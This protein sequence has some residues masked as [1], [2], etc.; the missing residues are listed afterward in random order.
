MFIPCPSSINKPVENSIGSEN[1]CPTTCV[2]LSF[3]GDSCTC[4]G[5]TIAPAFDIN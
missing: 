1:V 3:V 4:I 2:A 5:K